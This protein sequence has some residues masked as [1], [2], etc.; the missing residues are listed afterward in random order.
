MFKNLLKL[1]GTQKHLLYKTILLKIVEFMFLGSSF[2]FIY[3]T[4]TNLFTDALTQ[5]LG[6][7]YV[8]GFLL[9]LGLAYTVDNTQRYSINVQEYFVFAKERIKLGNYLKN[10]PMGFFNKKSAGDL[11]N[12]L[13]ESIKSI[14]T[15][16]YL[17][18]KIVAM[19]AASAMFFVAF[20]AA[21]WKM[22]VAVFIGIPLAF[23]MLFKV[24]NIGERE[25]LVRQNIQGRVSEA[26]VEFVSGIQEV[27]AFGKS[28]NSLKNYQ[29]AITDFKEQNLKIEKMALPKLLT[30]QLAIDIGFIPVMLLGAYLFVIQG[31]LSLPLYLLILIATLRLYLLLQELAGN[32][33]PI[34]NGH[35]GLT[36]VNNIYENEVLPEPTVSKK[37]EHHYIEFSQVSFAYEDEQVLKNISFQVPE[38]TITALMGPSGSGK[39]TIIKLL[40][41]MW[42]IKEGEIKIGG[43]NIKDV[44]VE[45][46]LSHISMVFQDVYLFN[47]TIAN[48]IKIGK[49]NAADEEVINAAKKA[50]CHEFIMTF[51]DKYETIVG[52]GGGKLSGGEKQRISIARAFLKD[53]PIVLLDEATANIDPENELIIQTAINKLIKNK[54]VIVIAHK[55]ATIKAAQ[56]IIVLEQGKIVQQGTHAKL[57]KAAG[58]IYNDYRRRRQK[59]RGWRIAN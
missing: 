55:L 54:T 34:K 13:T 27:K 6:I 32:I 11:S 45:E 7:Y 48:N 35:A 53:A 40:A 50:N 3:L 14:E 2:V 30:Y 23:Y 18:G 37:I 22:A 4:I 36:K 42:D 8:L 31:E 10:L 28:A 56:Q 44:K 20:L 59:A 57:S 47:D 52:E 41:R 51:P 9:C 46:L 26:A 17:F 19:L 12:T 15:V 33:L 25:L 24:L 5:Q 29:Q 39:T 1:Y 21:D 58:G 49:Q 43:I 16:P 38:N